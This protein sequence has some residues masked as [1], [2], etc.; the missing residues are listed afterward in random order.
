MTNELLTIDKSLIA[1]FKANRTNA[2]TYIEEVKVV[3][4]TSAVFAE[5]IAKIGDFCF[6]KTNIGSE[7]KATAVTFMHKIVARDDGGGFQQ[8]IAFPANVENYQ[9]EPSYQEFVSSNKGNKIVYGISILFYLNDHDHYVE[10]LCNKRGTMDA[11]EEVLTHTVNKKSVIIKTTMEKNAKGTYAV[12]TVT[13][14]NSLGYP[15]DAPK[16]IELFFK[17][18]AKEQKSKGRKH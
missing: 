5:G 9:G 18:M 10:F 14:I 1:N 7:I 12:L 6:G 3:Y 15:D 4:K 2:L 13:P 11:A 17:D 16:K 8:A